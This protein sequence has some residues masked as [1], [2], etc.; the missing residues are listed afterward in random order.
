M[1]SWYSKNCFTVKF[2]SKSISL[3][4]Y[5]TND[6]HVDISGV[7]SCSVSNHNRVDSFVLPLGTFDGKDTVS[8]GGFYV[9][10]TVCLCEHLQKGVRIRASSQNLQAFN[11]FNPEFQSQTGV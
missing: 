5:L 7:L 2:F 9:D 6:F 10:P 1:L 4:V 3:S 8:L 11:T